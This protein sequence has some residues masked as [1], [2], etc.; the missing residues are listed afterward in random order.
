M[1]LRPALRGFRAELDPEAQGG[2]YLLGLRQLGVVAHGRFG[3]DGI[4]AAILR[5]ARGIDED[6]VGRT[7]TALEAAGALRRA[8]PARPSADGATVTGHDD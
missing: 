4:A 8:A 7:Q 3:R 5:A 2:A 6:V 1:L